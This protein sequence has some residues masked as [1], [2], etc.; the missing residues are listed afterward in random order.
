[1]IVAI[2][3]MDLRLTEGRSLKAKRKVVRRVIERTRERFGVSVAEVGS[4]DLWQRAEI[5][6]AVVGADAR[7]LTSMID[8]ISGFVASTIVPGE[9]LRA[10]TEILR[11]GGAAAWRSM[12]SAAG[13]GDDPWDDGWDEV[14]EDGDR[15]ER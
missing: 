12:A 13:D 11:P 4:N 7:H 10:D 9:V 6:V 1:M 3:R 8:Q 5:G 2:C 15:D 14:D